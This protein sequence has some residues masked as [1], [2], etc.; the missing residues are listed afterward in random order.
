[1]LIASGR[2]LL[3]RHGTLLRYSTASVLSQAANMLSSFAILLW[4]PPATVGLWQSLLLIG[5]YASVIQGGAIHGLNRELPLVSGQGRDEEAA[6]LA[7]TAQTVALG[8]S[9]LCLATIPLAWFFFNDPTA[10]WGAAAVIIG[11]AAAVYGRYLKA[12][13]RA[14]STFETLGKILFAETIIG[15][16]TLSLVYWFGFAGL[17]IRFVVT[18]LLSTSLNHLFRP[19]RIVGH[20]SWTNLR[21][22]VVVGIPIFAFAYLSD[23]ARTFPRLI[24]LSLGGVPWVGLFAPANAMAGVLQLLPASIG[25][26]VYPKMT[27]RY[28]STGSATSLWPMARATALLP[29]LASVPAAVVLVVAAPML[30]RSFFPAYIESIPALQWTAIAGVFMGGSICVNALASL[31]AYPQMFIFVASRLLLLFVF[32]FA[33]GTAFGSLAGVGAGMAIAYALDFCVVLAL[34]RH[35][36]RGAIPTR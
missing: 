32:P 30:M 26:Y 29:L 36:T 11:A 19:L 12:T 10:R 6:S 4:L 5:V 9:G 22:L 17:A 33:L 34:V 31:K 3:V 7:G 21:R 27:F 2:R 15:L 13:Y 18:E 1:M 14:T 25:T 16:M 24:L 8:G 23:L 28:G 20:F 35:A